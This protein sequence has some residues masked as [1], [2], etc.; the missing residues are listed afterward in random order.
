MANYNSAYTGAEIDASVAL[1]DTAT[2]PSDIALMVESDVTGVTG[3]DAVTNIISLTQAE[4]DAVTPDAA[5]VYLITD[6]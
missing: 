3:A 2:Q 6:A 4:Y 1:A 5:T